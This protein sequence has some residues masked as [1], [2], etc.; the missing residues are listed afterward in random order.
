MAPEL[1]LLATSMALLV[2]DTFWAKRYPALTFQLAL[3]SLLAITGV[4]FTSFST[5]S[6]QLFNGAFIRDGVADVLKIA[7]L[8]MTIFAFVF[9]RE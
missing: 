9:A 7:M 1:L 5:E 3:V 8:L 2:G 6:V 4:I